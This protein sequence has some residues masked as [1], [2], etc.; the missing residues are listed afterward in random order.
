M[1]I[2]K[3]RIIIIVYHFDF[4]MYKESADVVEIVYSTSFDSLCGHSTQS[5][6]P[7]LQNEMP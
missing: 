1:L 2:T 4:R 6:Y 7:L 5:L 3:D